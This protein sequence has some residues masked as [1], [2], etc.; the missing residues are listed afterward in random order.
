MIRNEE[1]T[2][3]E[4][5]KELIPRKRREKLRKPNIRCKPREKGTKNKWAKKRRRM[6]N[7]YRKDRRRYSFYSFP[8]PTQ[9][10]KPFP[11]ELIF[12]NFT[13][14]LSKF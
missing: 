2:M 3:E 11:I 5:V 10:D 1:K 8:Q 13:T 4:K 6:A 7:N 12:I 14:S 9:Y